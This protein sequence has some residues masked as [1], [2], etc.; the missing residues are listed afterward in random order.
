MSQQPV[1][2]FDNNATTRVAP[3]VVEA[4][5]PFLKD[6]WGN[7][8]S[9]Y[10][11]GREVG[12]LVEG[13]RTKV[14]ALINADPREIIF[15]S[16][17]TESINSAIHNGLIT[18]PEKRQVVTTAVEHS[19]TIKFCDPLQKQGYAVTVL[20]VTRAIVES[21]LTHRQGV[22]ISVRLQVEEGARQVIARV[23][24][25]DGFVEIAP[26]DALTKIEGPADV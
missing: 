26:T 12:R 25:D 10:S 21:A 22:V 15:T 19:A 20:P 11:F 6:H 16:C 7:P 9:A 1:Y 8:S 2:Y 17:G 5:V 23:V 14:A 13:A 18:H 24:R 3:E 4:M